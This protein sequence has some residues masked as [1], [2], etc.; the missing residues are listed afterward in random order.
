MLEGSAATYADHAERKISKLQEAYLRKYLPQAYARSTEVSPHVQ[1]VPI[2]EFGGM[3]ARGRRE[4]L[5]EP[6]AA[7][8]A[9]PAEGIA[10]NVHGFQLSLL[11]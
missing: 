11:S 9:P 4:A 2:R 5:Q 1:D 6:E 7:E 8:S 3:S 10:I